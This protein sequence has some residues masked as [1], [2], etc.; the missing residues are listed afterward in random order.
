MDRTLAP[1]LHDVIASV[2]Q[3]ARI[4]MQA[5]SSADNVLGHLQLVQEGFGFARRLE[6]WQ[7]LAARAR[8]R[9][10]RPSVAVERERRRTSHEAAQKV[11]AAP[12]PDRYTPAT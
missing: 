8:L 9:R 1:A 3:Q 6:G 10:S 4:R 11:L 7:L 12:A 5:V 2:Y